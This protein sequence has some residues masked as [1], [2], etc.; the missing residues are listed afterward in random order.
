MRLRFINRGRYKETVE[1]KE[2]QKS[3]SQSQEVKDNQPPSHANTKK[4]HRLLSRST[5]IASLMQALLTSLVDEEWQ[6]MHSILLS[7]PQL[8]QQDPAALNVATFKSQKMGITF[9]AEKPFTL[10]QKGRLYVATEKLLPYFRKLQYGDAL[11]KEQ[12]ILPCGEERE[13]QDAARQKEYVDTYFKP[14]IE[15]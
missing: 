3:K 5:N 6:T 12:W 7:H 8:L 4:P 9:V 10:V 2:D 11:I 1:S 15:V 13:A 14:L